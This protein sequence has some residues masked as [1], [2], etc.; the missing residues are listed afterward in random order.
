[1]IRISKSTAPLIAILVI[2]IDFDR[3]S[4]RFGPEYQTFYIILDEDSIRQ[5]IKNLELLKRIVPNFISDI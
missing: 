1:M 5:W 3:E 4:V 2:A